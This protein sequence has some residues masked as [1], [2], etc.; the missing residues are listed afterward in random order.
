LALNVGEQIDRDIKA[1][2]A[3]LPTTPAVKLT[4]KQGKLVD[5]ATGSILSLQE[6]VTKSL[7]KAEKASAVFSKRA[8]WILGINPLIMP[9][10]EVLRGE[11]KSVVANLRERGIA[12]KVSIEELGMRI[13]VLEPTKH[14]DSNP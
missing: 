13:S 12:T 6:E 8:S 9:E 3:Q 7:A 10:I 1:L 14:R 11:I 5:S 4:D 2:L